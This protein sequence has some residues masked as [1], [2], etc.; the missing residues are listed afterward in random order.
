MTMELWWVRDG[1]VMNCHWRE[2]RLP[3][4]QNKNKLNVRCLE[5]RQHLL[6][7]AKQLKTTGR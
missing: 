6:L 4:G 5:S 2:Q 3:E 7:H 1:P